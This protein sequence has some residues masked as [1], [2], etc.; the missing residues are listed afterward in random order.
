MTRRLQRICLSLFLAFPGLVFAQD[1]ASLYERYCATCHQNAAD[2]G[3][4]TREVFQK[5]SPEQILQVLEK[6]AMRAQAAERSRAQRRVLAEYLS[7][8]PF[9]GDPQTPIP[10]TAFC[11][12]N[13][14]PRATLDGPAW[15]GWG[16]SITN[17][18]F[19]SAETAGLTALD[20]P[21]LKLKWAFGYPGVSSA[22]TAPVVAGGR[23]YLGDP[24]GDV[25]ALDAQTGCIYWSISVEAGI[26]S[27]ITIAKR[28]TGGLAAYF[29]DQA[30]NVYAVDADSGKTLWKVRVEDASRAGITGAPQLYEGIL[31]V[32]V[33]SREESAGGDPRYPCCTF[34]GSVVALNAAT[35]KQI[36]KTYMV[37][38]E[39]KLIGKNRAGTPLWGP[40]GGAVWNTPT[41]DVRRSALYVGT[42]NNYSIPATNASDS[43][44]ALD[45]K[46]GRIKWVHQFTADD[47]WN[48]GCLRSGE[49]R[50][51][52]VCPDAN[53]PDTDFAAS[54][55]LVQLQNGQQT[56]LAANKS[57]MIWALDP[58]HD[59]QTIWA[60]SVGKGSLQG[61]V[62][63]GFAVDGEK[64]YVPNGYFDQAEPNASG[65]VAAL[66][67]GDGRI[68]WRTPNPP[69]ADR[70]PCKPS[71]SAAVTVIPGVVF[72][73]TMDGHLYAYS[74]EDGRILLDL[75]TAGDYPTVN[76]VKANGGSLSNAGPAIVNGML[77]LNS[78]YS[79]HG[80][81][82]PG[83]VLLAF[84][85]E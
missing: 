29:G 41:I 11:S 33:S 53:A 45:L 23:L 63:W 40:S 39:P 48:T 76:S 68:V 72:S 37:R 21:R 24:E 79:H 8:K 50:D 7:G 57:G 17:S 26:R 18:R 19:V 12:A 3:V 49:Q 62:Q 51:P 47:I 31:Y 25:F 46:S 30:A 2:E 9:G 56:L 74:T 35:G 70:K 38:E 81:I 75:N 22:G 73:G 27:A 32:P 15:N 60:Q 82:I 58:D 16:A 20:V 78:G 77:Y 67:F 44:V 5:M 4:P 59:G 84:A 66:A 6:G 28:D 34:R 36:W 43:V 54:P 83:N 65:A 42:G 52:S 10:K 71:H 1:G 64:V 80:G 61:G 55:V 14:T 85:V 13:G 69:C